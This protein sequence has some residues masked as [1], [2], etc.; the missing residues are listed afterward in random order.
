M[1][2]FKFNII[3]LLL[4]TVSSSLA[5]SLSDLVSRRNQQFTP[6]WMENDAKKQLSAPDA[7]WLDTDLTQAP[8]K[9]ASAP[10]LVMTVKPT[11]VPT[12]SPLEAKQF[13]GILGDYEDSEAMPKDSAASAANIQGRLT[14]SN[15]PRKPPPSL[16]ALQAKHV[17]D[18]L[19]GLDD[20]SQPEVKEAV[21]TPVTPIEINLDDE[22]L[23]SNSYINGML[24]LKSNLLSQAHGLDVL[25]KY[26]NS[27]M[28]VV[29]N[30][31]I[32]TATAQKENHDAMV[33]LRNNLL[34]SKLQ[35]QILPIHSYRKLRNISKEHTNTRNAKALNRKY[36]R[37]FKKR[38]RAREKYK[39]QK[40]GF[41][42]SIR[43]S[44][45]GTFHSLTSKFG[46]SD[47]LAAAP[48]KSKKSKTHIKRKAK[49]HEKPRRLGNK[50]AI[51]EFLDADTSERVSFVEL[52]QKREPT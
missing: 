3:M 10:V 40:K 26:K 23:Y 31:D 18:L 38:S 52:C 15:E 24:S 41:L 14:F 22:K 30:T 20:P 6:N 28:P 36:K 12:L 32:P 13:H 11:A 37:P 43:A 21:I 17:H 1:S 44:L 5:P 51:S 50:T 8:V 39:K 42:D 35:S 27:M 29:K 49:K 34:S 33:L 46:G 16:S 9:S 47:S 19:E 2:Y 45:S 7:N 4:A 48:S 25:T